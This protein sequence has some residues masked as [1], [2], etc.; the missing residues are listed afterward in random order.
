MTGVAGHLPEAQRNDVIW[1][2][3]AN[4]Q[5]KPGGNIPLDLVNEFLNGEFKGKGTYFI[6]SHANA[7]LH[8]LFIYTKSKTSAQK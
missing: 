7:R 3:V 5:G 8:I 1:N 2:R 4:L 6:A